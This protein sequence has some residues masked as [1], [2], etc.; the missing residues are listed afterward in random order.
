[1][2]DKEKKILAYALKNA[3][4]HEGKAKEGFVLNSLFHDGLQKTKIKETLPKIKDS[5][6]Y[7]NSLK[8][9]DQKIELAKL[10]EFVSK[11]K[12]RKGLPEL[13]NVKGK[14]VMRFPPFPSGPLH[15]GNARA[16]I[17]ND[18]Y[19]KRY[20]G[21]LLLVID[22]TI[23]SEEKQIV[24]EAYELIKQ[25][26][27]L[28][29]VKYKQPILTKSSRLLIYYEYAEKLINLGKAYVCSCPVDKLRENR[30]MGIECSCRQF[31][32]SVQLKKWKQMFNA[33]QGE[34]TLRLKTNMQH[35]NPA[36]RDRVIFRIS[37]REHPI[38]KNKYRVWPL[39]EFS[40]AVDD[41]L[42][43][44]T[45]ILRG[46][47]LMIETEMEKYIFDIFKWKYPE[48]LHLG[49]LNFE[50]VKLSKSKGQ[51]EIKLGRYTGWD[52]PRTWSIQSMMK[53]GIAP[54]AIR[55]FLISLG[56]RQNEITVPI[57]ILYSENRKMIRLVARRA[58]FEMVPGNIKV[59]MPDGTI[60]KG[61]SS[62]TPKEN[63]IIH[64]LKFGY[65]KFDKTDN[66]Q[67]L[68]YFAHK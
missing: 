30:Q 46:K 51:K 22:D 43:G 21:D 33:K 58:D 60:V 12:I 10:E 53:R 41:H 19:A 47:E 65:C 25:G 1:M 26:V 42:L 49:L 13:P 45:H 34:F 54:E 44:I 68:F 2:K 4:E 62:I 48:F 59:I 17:L 50:G 23:G 11:R 55:K 27:E 31:P 9:E 64:F 57:D 29:G 36:F 7:V 28:L 40:W 67:Y 15:I 52:D 66:H 56:L 20:K 39:L 24:P 32:I 16:L 8:I 3:I 63:E 61:K 6:K 38:T 18:E 14:V 37:E 5:V 35:K